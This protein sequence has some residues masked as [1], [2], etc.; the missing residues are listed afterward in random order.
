M[1]SVH[2][3]DE[4]ANDLNSKNRKIN[5]P[6]ASVKNMESDGISKNMR[7]TRMVAALERVCTKTLLLFAPEHRR[8]HILC[9]SVWFCLSYGFYG[10]EVQRINRG[11]DLV[12]IWV[13]YEK[14]DRSTIGK[15][16]NMRIR[17]NDGKSYPL[18]EIANLRYERNLTSINHYNGK[19]A[20]KIEADLLNQEVN[21]NQINEEINTKIIP[22]LVSKYPGV[23][24]VFGGHNRELFDIPHQYLITTFFHYIKKAL[25]GG[26]DV[27]KYMV[28]DAFYKCMQQPRFN[29]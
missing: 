15:L 25:K 19:R 21:S 9:A 7:L 16:E 22:A 29:S 4:S 23:T 27:S 28:S 17:T 6:N 8:A 12:K 14:A 11:L 26:Q 10:L 5:S 2:R 18:N 1:D 13:R 3:S 20:V 24:R